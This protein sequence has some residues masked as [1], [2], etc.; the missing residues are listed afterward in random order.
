ML[1]GTI[2]IDQE[3]CKGCGLCILVCPQHVINLQESVFN[4]K[5]FHPAKLNDESGSCTGCGVCAV[6]CPDVSILVYRET[7]KAH[8]LEVQE[9]L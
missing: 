1:K 8:H 9:V 5:G 7:V 4:A 6:I 2:A 3:R